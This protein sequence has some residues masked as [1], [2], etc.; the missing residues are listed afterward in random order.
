MSRANRTCETCG[1]N[2][3]WCDGCGYS[4][5]LHDPIKYCS[6]YCSEVVKEPIRKDIADQINEF[7][8]YL[9]DEQKEQFWDIIEMTY[10]DEFRDNGASLYEIRKLKSFFEDLED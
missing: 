7:F 1:T 6:L 3:H 5:E 8:E 9:C 4:G 10:S 2:Y